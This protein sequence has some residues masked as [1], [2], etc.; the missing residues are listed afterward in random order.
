MSTNIGEI[1]AVRTPSPRTKDPRTQEDSNILVPRTPRRTQASTEGVAEY[2][3][4]K[5]DAPDHRPAFLRYA[6]RLDEGFI[7][8]TAEMA[9][10]SAR[11]PRAYFIA[12]CK[13]ELLKRGV[14]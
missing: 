4:D 5:F 3:V 12:S 1:L 14:A 2:L 6:W 8:R 10:T 11:N 7:N 9:L 13:R